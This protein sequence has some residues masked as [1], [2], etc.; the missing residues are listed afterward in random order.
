MSVLLVQ[1]AAALVVVAALLYARRRLVLGRSAVAAPSLEVRARQPLGRES[2]VAVV[3]WD[4]R[5]ILV[6]YG[7]SGVTGL[8]ASEDAEAV[9][10]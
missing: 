5:E 4:G 2:G 10:P 8:L 6:G 1:A 7:A 9:L 3:F